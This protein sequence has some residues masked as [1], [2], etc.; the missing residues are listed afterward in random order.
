MRVLV[1][2]A[3]LLQ[4]TAVFTAHHRLLH[5]ARQLQESFPPPTSY[6]NSLDQIKAIFGLV[7]N[8]T[9]NPVVSL[10]T[11]KDVLNA[12]PVADN[13]VVILNATNETVKFEGCP[14]NKVTRVFM[15]CLL[16][17]IGSGKSSF[18]VKQHGWLTNDTV[19]LKADGKEIGNV[20]EGYLYDYVNGK[21]QIRGRYED[22]H[23]ALNNK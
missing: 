8:G 16:Q 12:R 9:T 14:E 2:F 22:W 4:L 10:M 7:A 13:F 17:P 5:K 20:Q 23:K 6:D 3:L 18:V 15:S 1:I 19:L 21:L 11:L